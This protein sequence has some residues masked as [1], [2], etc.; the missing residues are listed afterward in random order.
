MTPEQESAFQKTF[1]QAHPDIVA[2]YEQARAEVKAARVEEEKLLAALSEDV[3]T[4]DQAVTLGRAKYRLW[5]AER[6]STTASSA[7]HRTWRADLAEHQK[8]ASASL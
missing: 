3:L 5:L 4:D 7:L 2:A 6:R 1:D 8:T